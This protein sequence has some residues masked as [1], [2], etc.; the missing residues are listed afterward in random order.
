MDGE[1]ER[2]RC[3]LCQPELSEDD[4]RVCV[5]VF[6]LAWTWLARK[7]SVSEYQSLWAGRCLKAAGYRSVLPQLSGSI[8]VRV[9]FNM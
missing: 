6:L 4:R 2:G 8:C 3:M 1:G 7:T 9:S 5:C